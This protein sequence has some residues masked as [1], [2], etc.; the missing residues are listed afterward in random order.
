MKLGEWFKLNRAIG[1]FEIE[2]CV[3]KEHSWTDNF[4]F[5]KF[6]NRNT[7]S[8]ELLNSIDSE[9]QNREIDHVEF[10]SNGASDSVVSAICLKQ[11]E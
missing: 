7:T 4:L 3:Y 5:R 6:L 9:M 11:K 2:V 1:W 8:E 10:F